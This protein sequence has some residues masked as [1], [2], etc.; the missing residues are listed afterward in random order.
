MEK[1]YLPI[2]T[3]VRLKGG[4]KRICISGF[5]ALTK[6]QG[7]KV[8]DYSGVIYPEGFVRADKTLVFDHIQIEEIYYMGFIDD[9]EKEF[10]SKLDK[11][12]FDY[13]SKMVDNDSGNGNIEIM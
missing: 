1:K 5:C 3:I 10:K 2:G 6:E 9:E 8:F 7:K 11:A 12:M 13:E 4:S